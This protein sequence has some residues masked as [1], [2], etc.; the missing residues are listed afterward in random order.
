MSRRR[1]PLEATLRRVLREELTQ[2]DHTTAGASSYLR[3]VVDEGGEYGRAF[4]EA[5]ANDEEGKISRP[6]GTTDL[7]AR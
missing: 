2:P 5:V 4:K 1:E 7:D 3:D 6:Q